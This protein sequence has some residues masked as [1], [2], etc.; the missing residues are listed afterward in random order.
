MM[1]KNH[2]FKWLH[3]L[4]GKIFTI[5]LFIAISVMMLS[6]YM[7]YN[8]SVKTIEENAFNYIYESM[9]YADDNLDIM[10][11][12]AMKISLVMAT[13]EKIIS[14][15]IKDMPIEASYE[16]YI[17]R[18]EINDFLSSLIAYKNHILMAAV[19]GVDGRCY[20][21]GG[22]FILRSII[23]EQWFEKAKNSTSVQIFYNTPE[24]G[25]IFLCRP[26]K[27]NKKTVA[28]AVIELDFEIISKV[29]N[30]APLEQAQI[31][32]FDA[33]GNIVFSNSKIDDVKNISDTPLYESIKEYRPERRY[34]EI[35]GE[36]KLMVL[37]NSTVNQLT[38]IGL[39]SYDVLITDALQ[40]QKNMLWIVSISIIIS[41]LFSWA[42]S[43]AICRN[44]QKL[45]NTMHEVEKGNLKIRAN[46]SG[47]DEI[48]DMARNFNSMMDRIERLLQQVREK[49]KQKRDAEQKALQAQVKPHFIYNALNSIKYVA[50]MR[51]EPEIEEVST[52][53]IELIRAVLGDNNEEFIPL[54]EEYKYIQHY[55][56]I[57]QFKYQRNF[58][59]VWDVEEELWDFPIPKLLLQPI[60]ENALIHGISR[61]EDGCINVKIYRLKDTVFMNIT[62]NGEGM[63]DEEIKQLL[64]EEQKDSRR[65][66]GIG[67]RNVIERIHLIYGDDFGGKITSLKGMFT[68]IELTL[69]YGKGSAR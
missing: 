21:T 44:I 67:L 55:M 53:L 35:D 34:Y 57:Q 47:R 62:D 23:S 17:E 27:Y 64:S 22:N 48:C 29:Y 13:N 11:D 30:I 20:Q 42:F 26:I 40:I 63:T 28:I 49:E 36:N 18:E 16:W 19:V 6:I 45:Q 15:S 1:L 60:I 56:K 51:N 33:Y 4:Q 37:Y 5:C 50:H 61:R 2:M 58:S 41:I 31:I 12:D 3:T 14:A 66:R 39:I 8:R 38:T 24:D 69:P 52:A 25:R 65:F 10:I 68:S 43:S 32:T 59:M 46:I 54:K 9:E 7:L